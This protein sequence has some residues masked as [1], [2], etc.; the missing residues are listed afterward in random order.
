MNEKSGF[1]EPPFEI[2]E[3][4]DLKEKLWSSEE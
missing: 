1:K 2:E 3:F 4:Y